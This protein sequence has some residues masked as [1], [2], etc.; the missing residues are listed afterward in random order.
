MKHKNY[1]RFLD[2]PRTV[3]LVKNEEVTNAENKQMWAVLTE[4]APDQTSI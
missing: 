3:R 2:L 1:G 4:S